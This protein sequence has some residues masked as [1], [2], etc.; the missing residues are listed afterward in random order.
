MKEKEPHQDCKFDFRQLSRALL[1][2]Y[3]P[4]ARRAVKI[5]HWPDE[6]CD[7]DLGIY[8][9]DTDEVV[10]DV[11][12]TAGPDDRAFLT[13]PAEYTPPMMREPFASI[14]TPEGLPPAGKLIYEIVKAVDW[15]VMSPH[16]EVTRCRELESMIERLSE[17]HEY[18]REAIRTRLVAEAQD[19]GDLPTR[20]ESPLK[21]Q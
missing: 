4:T 2:Q 16:A 18:S 6:L 19:R 1:E 3:G 8:D 13:L 15:I 14:D 10:G 21:R 11:D 20:N 7:R 12:F 9:Q 17:D 5:T